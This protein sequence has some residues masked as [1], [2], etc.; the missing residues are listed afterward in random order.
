MGEAVV[1]WRMLRSSQE[2]LMIDL[3]DCEEDGKP[4]GSWEQVWRCGLVEGGF[5]F[6]SCKLSWS[7]TLRKQAV[8]VFDNLSPLSSWPIVKHLFP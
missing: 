5:L 8:V 6:L 7:L 4:D 2:I 1:G 3:C